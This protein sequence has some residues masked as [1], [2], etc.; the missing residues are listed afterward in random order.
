MRL[1][2]WCEG[3]M[4]RLF[5][6]D[7]LLIASHND[8]KCDEIAALLSSFEI[9]VVRPSAFGLEAPTETG[10]SFQA[11]AVLK[12]V[13]A[14]HAA[15]M[16]ALGD[17]SG[18]SVDALSGAPGIY[19][20][21][22][23]ETE[24]GVGGI[25]RNWTHAMRRVHTGLTEVSSKNMR[26]GTDWRSARFVCALALAWPNGETLV[27]EGIC[28]GEIIWPPRGTHGFGYDPIFQPRGAK[29]S[30]G[31]M[32]ADEKAAISHRTRAFEALI[33]VAF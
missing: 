13:E 24:D 33:K 16:V 18:L 28:E 31:E 27:V 19:S 7:K 9:E 8:G 30:F 32:R 12:A 10:N 20:A 29:Q 23:A 2:A 22:W 21:R 25:D 15:N 6:K 4:A 26:R 11:N 17:D 14:S 1:R 3:G 5:L